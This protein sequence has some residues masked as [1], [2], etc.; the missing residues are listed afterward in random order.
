VRS[1]A[2][3]ASAGSNCGRGNPLGLFRRVFTARVASWA[4]DE[5]GAPSRSPATLI[6]LAIAAVAFLALAPLSQAKLVVNGFGTPALGPQAYGGQIS[7]SGTI[8]TN[9]L[10]VAVNTSGNGAPA[11]TTYVVNGSL[12]ER[13]ERFGPTGAWQRLWGQDVIAPFVNEAQLLTVNASGGTYTLSFKGDTTE[14][15]PFDAGINVIKEAL[16]ALPSIGGNA[17][18]GVSGNPNDGPIFYIAFTGAL[19]GSDQPQLSVDA[20]QL[21]GT[22]DLTTLADGTSTTADTGT[23]FEICTV[24]SECQNGSSSGP[25][26][27][28]QL[29]HPQG[30]ALNQANGHVYVS[31]RDNRRISEFD[32]DGNFVR[33][34][35]WDV[36]AS[37]EP[38][39]TGAGFEICE[40]ASE[41]K[42]GAAGANG[43]EFNEGF[44]PIGYPVTDSSN[45]V[46]VPDS[47]N[48]RVQEFSSSGAFIAAY[49]YD[50]DALGGGA[51]EK[52]TSTASGACQAG[53]HGALPGQFANF[54]PRQLALDSSGNVYVIDD[55]NDRVQKFD[56]GF[57]TA[58]DFG[59]AA[60]SA[61][62]AQAPSLVTSSQGG[63]R[64]DFAVTNDVTGGGER[65][66]V[67]LDPTDGSVKDTSLGG[68]GIVTRL[69][70]LG[71]DGAGKLYATVETGFTTGATGKRARAPREVL[72]LGDT[73]PPA[74]GL[75]LE[76]VTTK[77]DTT[78]TFEATVDPNG[79]LVSC[80]FQYSTDQLNWTDVP[81][82]GCDS[83]ASTG[84]QALSQG[85]I[86]LIPNT[87]Y[88][89]RLQASR[90]LLANSTVASSTG[91]FDT[92]SV[93]PVVSDVSAVE[94]ADTSARMLGTIDPRNSATTYVFEY[95]TTPALGSSTAPL[96]IGAGATPITVS[97]VVG[98]LS[99]DTTYYYR[100]LATNG[101]GSTPSGQKTLHTRAIPFPP[102]NPGSCSN[103]AVRTEQSSTYLPDCRAFEMV[104]PPD[105]N[106]GGVSG[107]DV[108]I[109]GA[110]SRDGQAAA[111]CTSALS[112]DPPSQQSYL[113]APYLS[114]RGAGGW[115]TVNPLPPYCVYSP[116]SHSFS[117]AYLAPQS[118]DRI[119]FIIP[120]ASSCA[121]SP[122]VSGAPLPSINLY[123][124]DLGTGS[125][126][127]DLL[128]VSPSALSAHVPSLIIDGGS[129]DLSHVVFHTFENQ[130]ADSPAPGHF[131][132]LYDW[133]EDGHGACVT[134]GGCISL[135]SKDPSGEPFPT[136][137]K[138]SGYGIFGSQ[139]LPSAVSENG[140]RI[141]FNN[142]AD[143]STYPTN[144]GG[145][146]CDLYMRENATTTFHVSASECTVSCGVDSSPDNFLWAT[147][148]GEKA[149]F[150][151]CAKLT[152]SSAE[153]E[154]CTIGLSA[155]TSNM[156]KLYRWDRNAAPEHR[157]TDLSLDHE[158]AD[159]SQPQVIDI[160]GA[161]TDANVAPDAN[162]APGNTVYFVAGGQLVFGE[163]APTGF[164]GKPTGLKLYRWRWNGGSPGLDYL[165][166]YLSSWDN[167]AQS[168]STH[169][170][171]DPNVDR[172]H[173]RV[174]A[175]GRYVLI[176]TMLR[177]DPA[178][179]RDSDSDF[180]RWDE[181]GGWL[182]IS[183]QSPGVPSAGGVTSYTGHLAFSQV[184]LAAGVSE[185]TISDDGQRIFFSTPDALVPQDVNGEAG[186]PSFGD[187]IRDSVAYSC[188]DIYEWHDGTV[189]L[190]TSGTGT[191]PFV[192]LGA[193][194]S[195]NDVF[196]TTAQRMVGWDRDTQIDIYDVRTGG[197]YPEPPAQPAP[198]EGAEQCH[199]AGTVPPSTTGAGTAVFEGP[200][201]PAAKHQT[202]TR[203]HR[204]KHHHKRASR[205]HQRAANH[206]RRAGR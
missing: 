153:A 53:V 185:H 56:P 49:G 33:A 151:S 110:F 147:S 105:K 13:V 104:S 164:D 71:A 183:C 198:C 204:K 62:S 166:P 106:Q 9:P 124:G 35:G 46:W 23:G 91:S 190:L 65:Q 188:A 88:F 196:F 144:C 125:P 178:A 158:P 146:I 162:A 138:I 169:I 142:D 113:C 159:G 43:G 47:G 22:A 58:T 41:C 1:H 116:E 73:P 2:K 84:V 99:K 143:D 17:N 7:G 187:P 96:A 15:I 12:G 111:F 202:K 114:R 64:L 61:F 90:P 201:N 85:A 95:G 181:A 194:A 112:G 135:V 27:G 160:V 173:I 57:T 152:D 37:G 139:L 100:L 127:F 171:L 115:S 94:V 52:C 83:L 60:L 74:P 184:E 205:H 145:P 117:E 195:G 44:E 68:A 102:A 19:A 176:Q 39:D 42:Q 70:G 8:N 75:T 108:E 54:A 82:P 97:Q 78:A 80:K 92:D 180:Y 10:G 20:S 21:T 168:S 149:F 77:T 189:G 130:T 177:L 18:I 55:G 34:W 120:E 197:G 81:A 154:T 170:E 16:G 156:Q 141:Y 38:N 66:I 32:A 25:A 191:K 136:N 63:T 129:A 40:V 59:T 69:G 48:G 137:S 67:E 14:P 126:N 206:N 30:V 107:S 5:S 36:I 157:L 199:G 150:Q 123:R 79:G 179:D 51:L 103:E 175:D 193:T 98:G 26:K 89:L 50:V 24:A 133:E 148:G 121:T 203:K 167:G 101:F 182:C 6:A 172:F 3:A 4:I 122:L 76:P 131:F 119:A 132:K 28:G 93:P 163:P 86:N 72:V 87:H 161:S 140:N 31:E 45:N 192:Y 118:F 29:N 109:R 165:G 200:G 174:T 155:A 11:G 186:C 134:P 128:G